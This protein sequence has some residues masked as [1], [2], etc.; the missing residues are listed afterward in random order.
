MGSM[1]NVS[2][3]RSTSPRSVAVDRPAGHRALLGGRA[4]EAPDLGRA[5]RLEVDGVR[6]H[7]RAS[8]DGRGLHGVAQHDHAA[9]GAGDGA[10][11][12]DQLP[13]RVGLDDLEVQ[14]GDLLATHAAGHLRALEHAGR[15]GAGTDR[16]GRAVLLVV[17][18]AGALALEVVPLHGAG[19]A[20]ALGDGDGVHQLTGL[21][22]VGGQLLADLVLGGVVEAQFDQAATGVDARLVVVALLGS[23]EGGGA[24]VAPGDLQRGV[25]L[26]LGGLHLHDPDRRDAQHRH[27]DRPVLVVPDLCHS[28]FF[29]HDRLGGHWSF[30]VSTLRSCSTPVGADPVLLVPRPGY[31]PGRTTLGAPLRP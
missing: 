13:L 16:T 20:L 21:E 5:G 1:P 22:Q 6:A 8:L 28:D 23:G 11:D 7:L 26:G 25:P 14:G 30:S 29:A 2:G 3:S 24:A 10:L 31:R 17:T 19:E 4:Q 15:G 18:V 27:R 12:Q 9:A